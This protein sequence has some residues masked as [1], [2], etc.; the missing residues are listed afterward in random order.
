MFISHREALI[1]AFLVL[2]H[3]S[4]VLTGLN[5]SFILSSKDYID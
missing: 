3:A 5:V 4:K 2:D 1:P